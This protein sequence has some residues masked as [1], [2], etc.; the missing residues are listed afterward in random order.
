MDRIREKLSIFAAAD[1]FSGQDN[2][3][4]AP[5]KIYIA[6]K[7]ELQKNRKD[8]IMKLARIIAAALASLVLLQGA[9][10]QTAPQ[11]P[12]QFHIRMGGGIFAETG[13]ATGWS[14]GLVTRISAGVEKSIANDWSVMA[15]GGYRGQLSDIAHAGW[16]G[17]DPDG[18]SLADAFLVGRYRLDNG[19]NAFVFG[20][21]PQISFVTTNDT[22]YID[23][24]PNH[25]LAGRKKFKNTDYGIQPSVYMEIGKHWELGIEGCFGLRNM[26]IRYPD[27]STSGTIRMHNLMVSAGFRF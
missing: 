15:G 16:Q 6:G 17:N 11:K 10:A 21:G 24:D 19:R 9:F 18:L 25:P 7:D 4:N 20:L 5:K 14:P 8:I 12:V 22:Y 27:F 23:A 26:R 13:S 3:R 2:A 1:S